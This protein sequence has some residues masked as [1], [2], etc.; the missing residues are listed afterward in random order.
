VWACRGAAVRIVTKLVDV[1][2]TQGVGV[3]PGDIPGYDCRG[4]LGS[5]LEGDGASNVGVT[6]DHSNYRRR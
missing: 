4:G 6:A 3:V 5:L 2:T 1:E